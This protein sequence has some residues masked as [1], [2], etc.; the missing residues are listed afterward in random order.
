LGY[1]SFVWHYVAK[2]VYGGIRLVWM[3]ARP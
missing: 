1:C 2:S 3:Q